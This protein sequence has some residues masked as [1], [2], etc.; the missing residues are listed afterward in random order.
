MY[1]FLLHC[2]RQLVTHALNFRA[3]KHGWILVYLTEKYG[4]CFWINVHPPGRGTAQCSYPASQGMAQILQKL[5]VHASLIGF[6]YSHDPHPPC[7]E[8][9]WWLFFWLFFCWSFFWLLHLM[10]TFKK[11]ERGVKTLQLA[12]C[13]L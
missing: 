5:P 9:F 12:E 13:L 1:Y 10:E 7:S 2:L 4:F 6:R 3:W 11:V 8:V